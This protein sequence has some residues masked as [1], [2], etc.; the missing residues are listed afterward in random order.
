MQLTRGRSRGEGE[1]APT[2]AE[3]TNFLGGPGGMLP[4]EIGH[5]TALKRQISYPFNT[6]FLLV[7]FAFV[8][9]KVQKEGGG[10]AQLPPPR[11]RHCELTFEPPYSYVY[12]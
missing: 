12:T 2:S 4:Q 7:N 11:I 6:T 1:G 8:K 3:G 9:K 5:F 10:E